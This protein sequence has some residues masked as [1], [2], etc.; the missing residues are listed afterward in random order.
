LHYESRIIW[1]DKSVHW[2]DVRGKVFYDS[3]HQPQKLVGTI[4]DITGQ[5]IFAN[6]LERQVAART[7]ELE[8]KNNELG[9]MNEELKSFAYVS[10]HDLQ[11]P[12][13]KIQTFSSRIREKEADNLSESGKDYFLRMEGAALRMQTLI[14]DLLTYSRTSTVER[15]FEQTDLNGIVAQVLNDWHEE[16]QQKGAVVKARVGMAWV[17]PFQMKQLLHNLIG[18]AL[19]FSRDGIA[20]QITIE[21]SVVNGKESGVIGLLEDRDY[22]HL[23]IADNGIGFDQQYKERIFEV[24]QRLHTR[25]VYK[26]TGIGL[27]IVKK[28]VEN[29]DGLIFAKGEV[30]V[31]ARFDIYLLINEQ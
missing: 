16:I 11:E 29:H 28:I 26:G 20:P 23:V 25:N 7:L 12:L 22:Y 13:R 9:K 18:N 30:N 27:A 19:K 3:E 1:D 24:F 8:K 15:Q 31:G 14:E 5:K 6:E 21:G 4:R 17:V 10:S 2:I